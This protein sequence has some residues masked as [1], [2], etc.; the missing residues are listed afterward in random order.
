M[1]V[2][3]SISGFGNLDAW[4]SSRREKLAN[5]IKRCTFWWQIW[6]CYWGNDIY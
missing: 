5:Y 3:N 1:G 6:W 4:M 2:E